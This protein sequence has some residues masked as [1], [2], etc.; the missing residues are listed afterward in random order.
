M[1]KKKKS[2]SRLKD[3]SKNYVP[4]CPMCRS[5]D[6]VPET[7][8]MCKQCDAEAPYMYNYILDNP[9]CDCPVSELYISEFVFCISCGYCYMAA[10]T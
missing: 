4:V 7:I 5:K 9:I 2:T 1:I 6:I 8:I 3:L 10:V